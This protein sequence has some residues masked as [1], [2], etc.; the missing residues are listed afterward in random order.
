MKGCD[1]F[2]CSKKLHNK[3]LRATDQSKLLTF[4]ILQEYPVLPL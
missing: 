2:E 3:R 4:K 1:N